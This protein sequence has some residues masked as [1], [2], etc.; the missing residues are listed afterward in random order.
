MASSKLTQAEMALLDRIIRICCGVLIIAGTWYGP[1]E[2]T[3]F[4]REHP[5]FGIWWPFYLELGFIWVCYGLAML[6]LAWLVFGKRR[7][8]RWGRKQG[9]SHNGWPPHL[10]T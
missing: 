6:P 8:G 3:R 2:L 5:A 1:W 9:A 10:A 4:I 7:L